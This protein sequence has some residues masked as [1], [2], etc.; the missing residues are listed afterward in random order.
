MKPIVG[1]KDRGELEVDCFCIAEGRW[2]LFQTI[3]LRGH[4]DL[5]K[6][7]VVLLRIGG[8][9]TCG[10]KSEAEISVI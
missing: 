8:A 6:N 9:S 1:R 7:I 2:V 4:L 10:S 5:V 3:A